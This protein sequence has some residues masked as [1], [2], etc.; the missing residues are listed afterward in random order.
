MPEPG[1]TA[2]AVTA[3]LASMAR[4]WLGWKSKTFPACNAKITRARW[5]HPFERE[6]V[7]HTTEDGKIT[8]KEL[9]AEPPK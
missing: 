6:V 8:M 4:R 1:V 9:R 2:A 7:V 5:W 3:L